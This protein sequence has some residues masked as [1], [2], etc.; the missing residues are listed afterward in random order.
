[1]NIAVI[2]QNIKNKYSGGRIHA[3][4]IAQ[5]LGANECNVD[6]YTNTIPIFE[7]EYQYTENVKIVK[8]Y[9]VYKCAK[10]IYDIIIVAPH[11]KMKKSIVFDKYI[12]YP[13]AVYLKNRS[14]CKIVFIDY[15]SPEWFEELMPNVRSISEYYYIEKFLKNVDIV[16]S[17]TKT[18]KHYAVKYYSKINSSLKYEQ[19]YLCINTKVAVSVKIDKKENLFVCFVR[20]GVGHKGGKEI[21]KIIDAMPRGYTLNIIGNVPGG[22]KQNIM[23]CCD[24]RSLGVVFNNNISEEEKYCILSRA[25]LLIFNSAFEGYGIPPVEAQFMNTPV[26]CSDLEVLRE[27][28]TK[29]FFTNFQSVSEIRTMM[30]MILCYKFDVNE[31]RDSVCEKVDFYKFSKKIYNIIKSHVR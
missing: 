22:E 6:Y 8:F 4:L 10:K 11:R 31:L 26:L 1:M 13:L 15:E 23:R 18:G 2:C 28:N 19:L 16:L 27:V 9:D 14:R 3:W 17:T 24:E 7:K 30:K 12:F 5:G 29:G 20:F 25:K 21:Y